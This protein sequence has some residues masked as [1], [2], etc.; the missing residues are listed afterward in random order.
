[1]VDIC[2][3]YKT[4]SRDKLCDNCD[5]AAECHVAERATIAAE[6]DEAVALLRRWRVEWDKP[7]PAIEATKAFLVRIDARERGTG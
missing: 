7:W 1:M 6:R 4:E 5:H 3:A 2:D